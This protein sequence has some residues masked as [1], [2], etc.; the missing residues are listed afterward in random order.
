MDRG[1]APLEGRGGRVV[2]LDKGVDGLAQLP[3]RGE[4]GAFEG[5]PGEDR[6]PDLDLVE[7]GRMGRGEVEV[8]VLV[9]GPPAIALG[10]V[11][12]QVVEDDVDLLV[13]I[14]GDHLVH[15]VEELGAPPAPGVLG[16]DLAG[17]DLERREQGGRAAASVL[18]RLTVERAAVGQ[19][20]IALRPL[21]RLDRWLLV[22]R[23]DDRVVRRREVEA[24]DAAALA[25]NSGSLLRH[26]E[27]R[28]RGRCAG[29]AGTR[30]VLIATSPLPGEQ[31][32]GPAGEP[33]GGGRSSAARMRWLTAAS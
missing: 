22:D 4:A 1:L 12:P 3:D 11:G 14:A 2:G 16:L 23:R 31:R 13:G 28:R 25:T 26:E 27:R 18:V 29:R 32:R 30:D 5:A 8:D 7:P 33:A 20:E 15:E 17:G 24:D 19:L 10:L 9:A 21:E 6:E